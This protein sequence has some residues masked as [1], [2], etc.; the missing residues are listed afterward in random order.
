MRL[1]DLFKRGSNAASTSSLQVVWSD[2]GL[3]IEFPLAFS[4]QTTEGLS[5]ASLGANR[6]DYMLLAYVGQLADAAVCEIRSQSV[7]VDWT[8]VYKLLSDAS[9]EAVSSHLRLPQFSAIRPV[10]NNLAT[11]SESRFEIVLD[12]WADAE[13]EVM[14]DRRVGAVVTVGGAEYLLSEAAWLTVRE[15]EIFS[16]RP[17]RQRTQHAN[18]LAW[19]RVRELADSA[20]SLYKSR[21]LETTL[22]L[23]P[24]SLRLPMFKTDT[25]LGRVITVNPTFENAPEG[26]L[27]AFDGFN[28]VQS[29]Y[30]LTRGV[31]R[32]RVVISEPVR[33][34]LQVIKRDMPGRRVAGARAE[35]FFQ[36]P[37]A[38]LGETAHEVLSEKDFA[39]D[40]SQAGAA[41]SYFRVLPRYENGQITAVNLQ[42]TEHFSTGRVSASFKPFVGPNGLADFVSKL[43]GALRVSTERDRF[44]WEEHDLSIDAEAA[45]QLE[46]AA[47]IHKL[48]CA[49]PMT[50][51]SLSDV[52]ELAGYSDRIVGIGKA[53]AAYVPVFQKPPALNDSEDT[54]WVPSDLTP[55]VSVTLQGQDG[56]VLIP[57]TQQWVDT[58]EKQVLAAE[59]AAVAEVV[60]EKLP[61]SLP[62]GQARRLLDIYRGMLSAKDQVREDGRPTS[63]KASVVKD[64][65]LVKTNFSGINYQEVRTASLSLPDYAIEELPLSLRRGLALKQHQLYAV[66]WLQHLVAKAPDGCRGALLA[67]DMGLGKT[68][69]LLCILAWYYE[70]NADAAPTVVFAPKS[71]L[72]NWAN[73]AKKFFTPS[74]PEVLV[75]YGDELKARK[76]PA[77]LID[78]QLAARGIIQLLKPNWV[79]TSKVLITT[80]ETLV[81]YEFSFARQPFA[82]V[83]CDEAQRLKTPGTLVTL[84]AKKLKANF[85]VA[86]TGTPVENSLTD[87]WCLFDFIQPGLLGSLEEFVRLYR[88]PIEC[89]TAEQ[90]AALARLQQLI[91]PQTLRRTKADIAAELPKKYFA[92]KRVDSNGLQFREKLGESE[93]LEI[94]ITDYQRVLYQGGIK[95]LQDAAKESDGLK[96]VNL[97][98]GALHLMRAVCAEPY[99]LPGLKFLV[100]KDGRDAHLAH[101]PKLRWTLLRL[102]K[103]RT[104]REKAIIFTD[105]REMQLALSYFLRQEF[106][107][108]P[109]IINGDSQGRQA[110]IDK[111]S[112]GIGFDVIILSTL[113]AGAGLNVTAANHVFHFTRAWNHAKETQATD[114]AY[115]IGQMRDVYV[116]CPT[117][118]C[119][120]FPTFELRLDGLLCKKAGL[121]GSTFDQNALDDMLNGAG[122][123]ATFRELIGTNEPGADL[124]KR[125]LTIDDVDRMDGFSFEVFCSMLWGRV[126]FSAEV[127]QKRGGDGGID[128]VAL[129][130]GG[131][132]E[133]IQ[134]KSSVSA[135]IGW[136]AIKEVTAGAARYQ[137]LFPGTRF[138]KVAVT[139][140]AFTAGAVLQAE[141]NQV[142]LV[143]RHQIEQM[144]GEYAISN[145]EFDEQIIR[146]LAGAKS[147][148]K[149][150]VAA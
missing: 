85:R 33:K 71:L 108:K 138:K 11:L 70:Q 65:L 106:G 80:Y 46:L 28:S 32:V 41:A 111:F 77:A 110:S 99:C 31:G 89:G 68:L 67:D 30:D 63:K 36:N 59:Q 38:F 103:I 14:V 20:G 12:A 35:K 73:E 79:G 45:T 64:V 132:G 18:E 142:H 15:I 119:G 6:D 23:T 127:T 17:L 21:Y 29:H 13:K 57:L 66:K 58:F 86:C 124:P 129:V 95:K 128:V 51:I 92:W 126:G 4:D 135:A 43:E 24:K 107:L 147:F 50:R 94:P 137:S 2:A 81:S 118:V 44:A 117:V 134:C 84:A 133:L 113:A 74:F 148:S 9:H 76:Q 40:R 125:F 10:L 112:E 122:G 144:L 47:Q 7:F 3:E 37:W 52:Y 90:K 145:H 26:W 78:S 8:A 22:V 42:V 25:P 136:D 109:F 149:L 56:Q 139:N 27:K 72:D 105:R 83:I 101:S 115:R 1:I 114:R 62:T 19:G 141:A 75:L 96:R 34:V 53:K 82:F 102:E 88:R 55:M 16:A 54:G 93:R 91:K 48:W 61:T 121:A 5:G 116:Y 97:S 69:Q 39:E 130:D 131:I 140:Q 143:E 104:L 120:Q 146:H 98:F 60:N 100:D 87:L 123:D 49:Q 150:A